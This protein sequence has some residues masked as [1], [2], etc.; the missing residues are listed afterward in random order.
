MTVSRDTSK[1]IYEGIMAAAV[2]FLTALPETWL[3][4]L[5]RPHSFT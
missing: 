1:A 2:R 3:V 4:C 5:L